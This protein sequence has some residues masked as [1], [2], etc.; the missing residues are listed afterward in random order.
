MVT[1]WCQNSCLALVLLAKEAI[2]VDTRLR[3]HAEAS[4][5]GSSIAI[6]YWPGKKVAT[7]LSY[8]DFV[9]V[10]AVIVIAIVAVSTQN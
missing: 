5:V 10:I 3:E 4:T 9:I 2:I 7:G 6:A 8:M 1:S